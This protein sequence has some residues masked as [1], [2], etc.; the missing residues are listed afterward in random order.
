MPVLNR[1]MARSGA[2]RFSGSRSG[3]PSFGL[4][5]AECLVGLMFGLCYRQVSYSGLGHVPALALMGET[6]E[7]HIRPEYVI[8]YGLGDEN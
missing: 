3:G 5:W 6:C 1:L 4:T 7:W 2:G 8:V